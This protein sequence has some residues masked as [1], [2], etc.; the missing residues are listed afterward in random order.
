M[1]EGDGGKTDLDDRVVFL[2]TVQGRDD[3]DAVGV[4]VGRN[5]VSRT[6]WNYERSDGEDQPDDALHREWDSPGRVGFDCRER[7]SEADL[8]TG[9]R[10]YA[11]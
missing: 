9:R 8:R 2:E 5:E 4:L 11:L 3:P 1:R 7:T 10:Q 6:L